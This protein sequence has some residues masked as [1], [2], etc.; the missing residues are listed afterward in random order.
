MA[1]GAGMDIERPSTRT[2][3]TSTVAEDTLTVAAVITVVVVIMVA[4]D[5]MAEA[6]GK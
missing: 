6:T 3:A 2:E 1:I 4:A 5:S